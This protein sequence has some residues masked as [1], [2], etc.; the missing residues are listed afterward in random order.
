MLRYR[1]TIAVEDLRPEPR[2][3]A[4]LNNDGV[5]TW[6]ELLKAFRTA[7]FSSYQLSDAPLP[8]QPRSK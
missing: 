3:R 2:R 5:V 7:E 1:S 4:D 8:R 6:E